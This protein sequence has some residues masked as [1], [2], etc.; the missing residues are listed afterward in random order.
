MNVFTALLGALLSLTWMTAAHAQYQPPSSPPADWG[1]VS[2]DLEEIEYPYPVHYLERE[3]F[4]ETVRIAYMD[5]APA[6]EPNGRT[7]YLTH[8]MSY[9]GWYWADTIEA[10]SNE[11]YRVIAEDRL[12]WGRSSKPLIPYSWHLH[13]GNKAALMDH[14]GVEQAAV[15]G[16]SM[17]GQMVSRFARLYPERTTHMVMVN[18]IGLGGREGPAPMEPVTTDEIP[19]PDEQRSVD[20]QEIYDRHLATE[21]RRVVE[22]QPEF[23]EHVRI[24]FGND[25]SDGGPLKAAVLTANRTG[26]SMVGDWPLIQAKSLIIG[27]EEDGPGFPDAV[28]R[29]ADTLPNGEALLFPDVGHNPHLEAPELLNRELIRFLAR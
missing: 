22:W 26:D 19:Q 11:G 7:V 15:I 8:G 20:R 1:P 21:T 14:L 3:L 18:P 23:L 17:G 27:G 28:Q 4:G 13:A 29:A 6:G 9:Y 12:G 24:R 2:I 25:I 5:V 16:H 10:L